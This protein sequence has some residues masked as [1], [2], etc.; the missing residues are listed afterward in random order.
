MK[1]RRIVCAAN[2]APDGKLII[3]IR[4]CDA[5]M[6]AA[7]WHTSFINWEGFTQ[8]FVDNKGE[9]LTRE[10]AWEVAVA[11][12]QLIPLSENPSR[13]EGTLYSEDLY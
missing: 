12:N 8:G 6:V 5:L 13:V 10:E 11:A 3:G 2:K 4:H 1:P 7:L 9:F